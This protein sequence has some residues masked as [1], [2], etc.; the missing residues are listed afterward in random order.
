MLDLHPAKAQH[1]CFGVCISAEIL[2]ETRNKVV[3]SSYKGLNCPLQTLAIL[4]SSNKC[5]FFLCTFLVFGPLFASFLSFCFLPYSFLSLFSVI[6]H[7]LN[8]VLYI[9]HAR[10]LAPQICDRD[11]EHYT[12]WTC[13]F[14]LEV[15]CYGS[16]SLVIC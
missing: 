11:A 4:Y 9:P 5:T 7:M 6:K 13:V 1:F 12:G 16:A 3:Y 14:I 8:F 15:S 2:F 10:A